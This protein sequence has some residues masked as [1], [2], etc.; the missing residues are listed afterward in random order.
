MM[1]N[2]WGE[3]GQAATSLEP[4]ESQLEDSD[5]GRESNTALPT[6]WSGLRVCSLPQKIV[7]ESS[8]D[9]VGPG[10]PGLCSPGAHII[11]EQTPT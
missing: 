6:R 8:G 10:S 11:G 7:V 3:L 9:H 5:L 1:L 2:K 4:A